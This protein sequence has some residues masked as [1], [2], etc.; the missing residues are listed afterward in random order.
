MILENRCHGIRPWNRFTVRV[1]SEMLS[2][3]SRSGASFFIAH[4][5]RLNVCLWVTTLVSLTPA[6]NCQFFSEQA[7]HDLEMKQPVRRVMQLAT[8]KTIN[9]SPSISR[10]RSYTWQTKK[11]EELCQFCIP[12]SKKVIDC[13]GK[14]HQNSV[15]SDKAMLCAYCSDHSTITFRN[16]GETFL[17][18]TEKAFV[19]LRLAL[20]KHIVRKKMRFGGEWYWSVDRRLILLQAPITTDDLLHLILTV[21][22]VPIENVR[23]CEVDR[24]TYCKRSLVALYEK[25]SKPVRSRGLELYLA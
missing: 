13:C 11:S 19:W 3:K 4:A 2:S 14:E 23:Q 10:H 12:F 7:G 21:V 20:P 6:K 5:W 25:N 1:Q 16:K 22:C 8:L 15:A 24:S 18:W 9:G 17:H